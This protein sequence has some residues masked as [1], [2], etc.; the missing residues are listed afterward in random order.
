VRGWKAGSGTGNGLGPVFPWP[1]P[2]KPTTMKALLRKIT[3]LFLRV[4]A[5]REHRT[6]C[7]FEFPMRIR[8][9]LR[10]RTGFG[11]PQLRDPIHNA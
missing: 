5:S 2:K 9:T 1:H 8:E 11:R 3:D 6:Q 10:G 4:Q 7:E